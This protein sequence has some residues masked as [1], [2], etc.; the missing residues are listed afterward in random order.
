MS[1]ERFEMNFND[2]LI[3]VPVMITGDSLWKN[4]PTTAQAR[5]NT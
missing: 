5:H 4:D 1:E 3:T 2:W